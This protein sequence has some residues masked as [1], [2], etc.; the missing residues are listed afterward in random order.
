MPTP[1]RFHFDFISPYAYLAWHALVRIAHDEGGEVI[2]VP[3]LFAGL[4]NSTGSK[5]PAE[6]PAKRTYLIADA[7]RKAR[8]VGVPFAAP[9]AHPFDPLPS[10]RAVGVVEDMHERARLV[11]ALF[12]A[13]WGGGTGVDTMPKVVAIANA[14]GLDGARVEADALSVEGKAKLRQ[15]T[16]AAIAAGV[17]GVPTM[18]VEGTLLWG[19]DALPFVRDALRGENGVPD[20]VMKAWESLPAGRKRPGM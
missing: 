6:V 16:D 4:L 5:G 14:L 19:Y 20:E 12:D 8:V 15:S 2:P 13:T 17:F 7:Y 9:P 1:I 3:T 10:L 11:T 18:I